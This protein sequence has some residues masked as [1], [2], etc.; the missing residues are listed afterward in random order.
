[1]LCVLLAACGAAQET[2]ADDVQAYYD[3]LQSAAFQ[4]KILSDL[5]ESTL[6]YQADYEYNTAAAYGAGARD[7]A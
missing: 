7:G 1:M 3:G 4:V 6:E 5:G 2:G